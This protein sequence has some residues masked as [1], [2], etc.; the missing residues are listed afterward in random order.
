[1]LELLGMQDLQFQNKYYIQ[2]E[3][4]LKSAILAKSINIPLEKLTT[5]TTKYGEKHYIGFTPVETVTITFY[6]TTLFEVYS[7][8]KTWKDLIFNSTT[9]TFNVLALESLKY[10][11]ATILMYSSSLTSFKRIY[12]D[13]LMI[14]GINEITLDPTN[15]APLEW[16]VDLA[17]GDTEFK[18]L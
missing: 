3:G 12:F 5:E 2:M 15:G 6:E 8:F 10:R 1:M 14:L 9:K 16:S 11:S 18:T 4:L 17:V 7:Y 13:K